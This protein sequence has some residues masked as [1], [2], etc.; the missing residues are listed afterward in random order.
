MTL[1]LEILLPQLHLQLANSLLAT[2][3]LIFQTESL[4]GQLTQFLLEGHLNKSK[5]LDVEIFGLEL[6]LQLE[7]G[8][9]SPGSFV[10]DGPNFRL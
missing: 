10:L 2:L 3:D 4:L 6:A 9:I 8:V 5:V 1:D 7:N